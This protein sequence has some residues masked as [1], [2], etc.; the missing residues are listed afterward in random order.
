M[1][2]NKSFISLVKCDISQGIIN[3]MGYFMMAVVVVYL[4]MIQYNITVTYDIRANDFSFMDGLMHFFMGVQDSVNNQEFTFPTVFLA[5]LMIPFIVMSFYPSNDFSERAKVVFTRTKR[6]SSW[7]Y[8]KCIWLTLGVIVYMAFFYLGMI[9]FSAIYGVVSMDFLYES[10]GV[11]M[12]MIDRIVQF[13][14]LPTATTIALG[15]MQM[16]VSVAT[17]PLY[18]VLVQIIQF[19]FSFIYIS[20]YLP[21]NYYMYMRSSF[22]REDGIEA[23]T[24]LIVC[25]VIALVSVVIG[26]FIIDKK[27][28]I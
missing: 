24:A 11:E 23:G 13:I 2:R 14:V 21:G 26:K 25:G 16:V 17:E 15:L 10:V 22:Y 3:Y 6:K 28:I 5:H 18:G 7:W 20:P 8:S 9:G 1:K 12:S 27:D 4:A 19:T